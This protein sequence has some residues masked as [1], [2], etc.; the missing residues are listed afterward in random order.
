M[1][2]KTRVGVVGC[3]TIA[4]TGVLPHLSLDDARERVDLIAVADVMAERARGTAEK[5]GIP[6]AYTDAGELI[7]RGDID[8]VLVLTP[9][10]Y[11][12]ELALRALRA[13]KHVYVQKTMATTYAEAQEMVTAA[14]EH[15]RVLT[16]APGQLLSPDLARLREIVS[17]GSLGK[18]YWAWGST[19]GWGHDFEPTRHGDDAM[20]SIDPSWY[21]REGGPVLDTT[22]YVLHTL[23]GILGPVRQVAG[24]SGTAVDEQHWQGK[25]I[26]VTVHDN[27]LLLLDFG[28]V[29]FGVVGGHSSEVGRQVDWGSFGI[30]G[31]AGVA[32]S[33]EVE[34]LTGWPERLYLKSSTP[35]PELGGE[36][37]GEYSPGP[38]RDLPVGHHDLPEPHVFADVMNTVDAIQHG[39][40]ARASAT[41]AA[42]VVEVIEKGYEAARD[43]V[44]LK[45]SSTF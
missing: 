34:P 2:D 13:G 41:Q 44:T 15:D 35:L 11:H 29:T 16:S 27:T 8:L 12:Y 31:S 26:P 30:Y 23:T 37:E 19:G 7:A 24:M 32:E 3:G 10:P 20:T 22:V 1:S 36:T 17:D 45:I 40:P 6:H 43:G 28:E 38:L 21:Y 25:A 14:E 4:L 42:H 5:F 9:I 33:L 18:I 39:Q